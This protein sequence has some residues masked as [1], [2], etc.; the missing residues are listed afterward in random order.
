HRSSSF[1]GWR[2]RMLP[3]IAALLLACLPL[4]A[5]A[6]SK[7]DV[8]AQFQKWVQDDLWPEARKTGISE[9]TFKA[10]FANVTLDWDL[11]DLAPP[12]F[13]PQKERKQSQAEF[14]SP[15][16]YFN[17][18]RLQRLAATGRAFASQYGSTLKRIERT[19]GVPGPIVLAIWGR[20]TGFG[21]AK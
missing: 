7:V 19:Y 15:A 2:A 20:E 8:E 5:A 14:S 17:E 11:P 13:P 4:P 21:A 3:R 10:A 6:A 12:G 18:E 1:P 9:K 16:P